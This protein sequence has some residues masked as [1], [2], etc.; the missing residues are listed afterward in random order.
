MVHRSGMLH[1]SCKT[2][3]GFANSSSFG[4]LA[5]SFKGSNCPIINSMTNSII[6]TQ[7]KYINA[8]MV[9]YWYTIPYHPNKTFISVLCTP[10]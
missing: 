9:L 10:I 4:H 5:L 3:S 1:V 6:N 8:H 2:H 7:N